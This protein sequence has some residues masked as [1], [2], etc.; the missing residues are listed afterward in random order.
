MVKKIKIISKNFGQT[1]DVQ[2]EDGTIKKNIQYC[3]LRNGK[4]NQNYFRLFA[5]SIN[6]FTYSGVYG[7]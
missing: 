7:Y 4:K 6:I 1:V 5:C 2:F 3:K